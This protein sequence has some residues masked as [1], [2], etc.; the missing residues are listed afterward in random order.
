MMT[1]YRERKS[2][3][4]FYSITLYPTLFDDFMLLHQCGKR[5]CMKKG[6]REYFKSKK[7]ALLHSLQIIEAKRNEGFRPNR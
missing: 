7:E 3:K 5:A 1:L 4:E 6:T 2:S